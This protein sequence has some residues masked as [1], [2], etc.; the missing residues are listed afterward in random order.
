PRSL[1]ITPWDSACLK[2]I[3][4]AILE[5]D[6]GINPQNDGKVIRLMFPQLTEERRRDLIKQVKKYTEEAK[7]AIRNI[8]RDAVEHY[9]DLKKKSEI[10]EDDLKDVEKDLQKLT[11]DYIKSLDALAAKKEKELMAI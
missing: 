7:I 5:S 8:R 10:T 4:K 3:E 9:K 2:M 6:L 11:D 1:A